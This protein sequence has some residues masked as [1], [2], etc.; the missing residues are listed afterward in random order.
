MNMNLVSIIIPCYND[1]QYIEQ[2]VNSAL[3]Q[4]YP[5]KEIILV[6]DGS[7]VETKAVLKKLEHK[8]TKLI[9]QENQGQSTARNVGIN[10]A[11]GEF[12][13]VL[14]SD[15]YFEPSFC[16]KAIQVFLQDKNVKIATCHAFRLYPDGSKDVFISKGGTILNFLLE[17]DALG[18]S[19]FLKEDW[20]LCGGYDEKMRSGFED[21]EFFIRVLSTEGVAHVIEEPLYNYRKRKDSTTA[22]ANK[23]KYNLLNYI[24][25]KHQDLYKQHFGLFVT[26]LLLKIEKEENEK[27]KHTKRLE[28]RIGKKILQPLRYIKSVLK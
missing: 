18:T 19:M 10:A 15:D 16:E 24:Y 27:I 25:T 14:D 2:A 12:I 7:N 11:K 1:A 28:F 5:N 26:H 8:I 4:T 21:W 9:T 3:N 6:D 22:R 20:L 23:N 13:L 17:N